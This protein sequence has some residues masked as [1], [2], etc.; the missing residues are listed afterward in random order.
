VNNRVCTGDGFGYFKKGL[1]K[2]EKFVYNLW[3]RSEFLADVTRKKRN[4][5]QL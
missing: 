4:R 2:F 5:P 3:T 1:Q